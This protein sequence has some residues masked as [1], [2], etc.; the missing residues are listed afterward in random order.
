[1]GF[2][3]ISCFYML[4]SKLYKNSQFSSF[5]YT[6]ACFHVVVKPVQQVYITFKSIAF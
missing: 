3:Y 4:K 2:E 1:M 5:H 6:S